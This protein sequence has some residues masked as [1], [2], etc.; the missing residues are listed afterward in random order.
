MRGELPYFLPDR[1]RYRSKPCIIII[2]LLNKDNL[3]FLVEKIKRGHSELFEELYQ[4][5]YADLRKM[6]SPYFIAGGDENDIIQECRIGLLKAVSDYNSN[7]GMTFRN[8]AVNICCKRHLIT[9]VSHANRKKYIIH[10]S[11]DSLDTPTSEDEDS[12]L[13]DFIQD[14]DTNILDKIV[15]EQQFNDL[16]GVLCE[17]LT[18]L[19]KSIMELYLN[20]HSYKEISHILNVKPK[21]VDNALM[22]IRHKAAEVII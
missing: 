3:E 5:L 11:A 13:S 17:K 18:K 2:G 14:I 22:R 7:A 8:F 6:S 21:T 15:S 1:R 20:G 10:N 4:I 16:K 19:E 9:T 12:N